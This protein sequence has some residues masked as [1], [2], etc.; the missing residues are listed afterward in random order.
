MNRKGSAARS[1]SKTVMFAV[2]GL[3]AVSLGGCGGFD[4]VQ[5]NGKIFDAMGVS[6]EGGK[7]GEP[8]L[9]QRSGLVVPPSTEALPVPGSRPEA[10]ASDVA[11]L[12]D[13][14]KI[15]KVSEAEKQR[16]QDEYCKVHYEQ[17]KQRND[18][19]ADLAEGPLGPCKGSVISA[20]K[21]W[22][23]GDASDNPDDTQ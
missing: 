21:K 20:L 23:G 1:A 18:D 13:P 8:K 10:E 15:A 2:A 11:A 19:N 7:S 14:D 5:L 3:I 16:Q 4:G 17:A 12:Q 9:A 6:G 22:Q